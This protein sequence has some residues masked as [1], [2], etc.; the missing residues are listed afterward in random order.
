MDPKEF[1]DETVLS[2]SFGQN[3]LGAAYY[4]QSSCIVKIMNDISEDHEFVY[5]K[6]CLFIWIVGKFISDF[7]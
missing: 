2:I 6:R 1:R 7:Q 4:E 5:F 3:M